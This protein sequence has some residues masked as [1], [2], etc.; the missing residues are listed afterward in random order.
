MLNVLLC[1][2]DT[3][4]LWEF[5]GQWFTTLLTAEANSVEIQEFSQ[6]NKP[7]KL[8]YYFLGRSVCS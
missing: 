7:F 8:F 4:F 5:L 6:V 3:G 2:M 1:A